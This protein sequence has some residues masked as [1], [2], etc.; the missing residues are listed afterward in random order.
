M[1]SVAV[2]PRLT[3]A[4]TQAL[5]EGSA[6]LRNLLLARLIGPDEMGLAV[7]LALGIRIVEMIGDLGLER[8]LVQVEQSALHDMRRVVHTLQL[9]KGA[10]LV[11]IAALL[12]R[13]FLHLVNPDIDQWAFALAAL[14]LAIRG[15]ANCDYREQQRHGD[16]R[17]ALIVEGGSNLLAA[18]AVA[19]IAWFSRDYT[20]LVWAALVQASLLCA[21]SHLVAT[22]RIAFGL[23]RPVLLRSLRYGFPV[24]LNGALMFF[25]LQGDRLIVALHFPAADLA[26]F[27][28]AAQLALLPALVG[29]RY[30]LAAELP[31]FAR[32][33]D[34]PSMSRIHLV[35]QLRSV[36]CVAVGG[37]IVLGG[38]GDWLI[39]FLYGSS[40][41][42]SADVFWLLTLAAALRLVRAV[43][44]T[45]L[46]AM[47]R[48]ATVMMSNLLRLLAVPLAFYLAMRGV[49]LLTIVALGTAGEA[50]SLAIA[51]LVTL[52]ATPPQVVRGAR[53]ALEAS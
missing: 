31:R 28:I 43:P 30:I 47:E 37:A 52:G 2:H 51:L 23:Q 3:L 19:P 10:C 22:R 35:A 29:A 44:N 46:I 16:F 6:F 8:L 34:D 24:A 42:V 38:A 32:L 13:N 33:I 45:Q 27:A 50:L 1:K 53:R 4:A 49:D 26:R 40:Y 39:Q 41:A 14:A 5:C 18:L 21:F 20:A 48:T 9:F 12:A 11:A 25:A 15:A 17:P 36:A 7:A